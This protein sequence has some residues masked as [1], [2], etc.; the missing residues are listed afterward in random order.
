MPTEISFIPQNW[1]IMVIS[2]KNL[3]QKGSEMNYTEYKKW[4]RTYPHLRACTVRE[5]A[6]FI[7]GAKSPM[8]A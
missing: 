5:F 1:G 4:I 6:Q 7:K 2:P 3:K 8:M